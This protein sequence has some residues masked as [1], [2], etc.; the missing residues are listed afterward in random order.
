[1]IHYVCDMCKCTLD[2]K[3][4][5]SYVVRMEVYAAPGEADAMIDDDRDYLEDIHE[6]LER[7]DESDPDDQQLSADTYQK[8]RFDL[9]RDC[10]ER[11]MQDPLSRRLTQ[12]FNFSKR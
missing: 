4:D 8:H 1:M 11:F 9:C 5:L 10:A 6:I 3:H 12:K 2:P 7:L